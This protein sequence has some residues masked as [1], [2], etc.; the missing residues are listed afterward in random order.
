LAAAEI[1][2]LKLFPIIVSYCTFKHSR[3]AKFQAANDLVSPLES[4]TLSDQNKVLARIAEE[5]TELCDPL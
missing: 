3:L 2:G 4:L 5:I 1:D